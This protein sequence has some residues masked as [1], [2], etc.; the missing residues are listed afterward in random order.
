VK[1]V[2]DAPCKVTGSRVAVVKA[3]R[4]AGDPARLV[5]DCTRARK[6]LG[7]RP[8]YSGLETIIQHAWAWER[9]TAARFARAAA[10]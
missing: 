5:A 9:K 10:L 4:R 2:I 7:W 6:E 8:R 3:P 1:E